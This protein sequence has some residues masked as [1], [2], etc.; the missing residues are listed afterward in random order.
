MSNEILKSERYRSV[1]SITRLKS[2]LELLDLPEEEVTKRVIANVVHSGL[3]LI[4]THLE[5]LGGLGKES[6]SKIPNQFSENAR[7]AD[8]ESEQIW[9]EQISYLAEALHLRIHYK[10]EELEEGYVG[11]EDGMIW[12][13]IWDGMDGTDNYM[14]EFAWPF[15][16]MI[17]L[18]P[19]DYPKYEDFV[20]AGNALEGAD[21]TLVAIK[22][23]GVWVSDYNKESVTKLSEFSEDEAY[24]PNK[25]LADNYF[26]EAQKNLGKMSDV[27]VR[28]GSQAASTGAI[29]LGNHSEIN[30]PSPLDD[31]WQALVDVTRKNNLEQ[32]CT[33]LMI[34]N[35]EV[36]WLLMA[37]SR[38]EK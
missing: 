24:D 28:T 20:V 19:G 26:P 17:A 37:R 38:L 15:G 16:T 25:I 18:A 3:F 21:L 22:N 30:V 10:G 9:K 1:D 35:W 2:E 32:P 7:R 29:V 36:S 6:V 27:W 8:I 5:E 31:G 33:Y 12:T 4:H 13:A 34:Q 23:A 14:K 11:P